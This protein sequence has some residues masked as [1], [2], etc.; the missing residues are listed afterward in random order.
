[1]KVLTWPAALASVVLTCG[2]AV[3]P[4]QAAPTVTAPTTASTSATAAVADGDLSPERTHA[5]LRQM[6]ALLPA[7]FEARLARV[8]ERL[9]IPESAAD[10]VARRAIDP[11]AH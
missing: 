1:M 4:V 5:L 9:G 2:L 8:N 6:R 3:A 7:D 11:T 10:L